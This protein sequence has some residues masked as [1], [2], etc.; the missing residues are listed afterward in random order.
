MHLIMRNITIKIP[1]QSFSDII[2]NSSSEL[3]AII[4]SDNDTLDKIY[5]L[6]N[7]LFGYDQES[8]VTPVVRLIKRPT[9]SDIENWGYSSWII[10]RD[11]KPEDYPEKWIEIELPYRLD[12]CHAFYKWGLEAI[13]KESFGNNFEIKYYDEEF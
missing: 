13:L 1:I 2:T 10:T 4:N 8:E 7:R 3:F 12:E 6:V 9:Q 11:S 5:E